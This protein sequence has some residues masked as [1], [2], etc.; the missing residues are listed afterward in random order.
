MLNVYN[1]RPAV[2]TS[3]PETGVFFHMS[4]KT[5]P[6]YWRIGRVIQTSHWWLTEE[7]RKTV[8]ADQNLDNLHLALAREKR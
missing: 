3:F 4:N 5:V 2:L 6:Y 8:C 1:K 7:C